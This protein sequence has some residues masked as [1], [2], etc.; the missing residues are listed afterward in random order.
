MNTENTKMRKIHILAVY[1]DVN[2]YEYSDTIAS[3]CENMIKDWTEVTDREF[4]EIREEVKIYNQK[5]KSRFAPE[6]VIIEQQTDNAL[7]EIHENAKVFLQKMK[8]QRLKEET[9]QKAQDEKRKQAVLLRKKKQFEKLKKELND[10][11]NKLYEK[12]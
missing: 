9:K 5:N 10:H 8:E 2:S 4:W 11:T 12:K 1:G 3:H 6:Y 7:K